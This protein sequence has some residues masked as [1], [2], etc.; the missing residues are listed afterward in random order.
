MVAADAVF[1]G[2]LVNKIS[3]IIVPGIFRYGPPMRT[4][5]RV[6]VENLSSR[7]S[8]QDLKDY[9]R[10]EADVTFADAHRHAR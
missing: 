2:K 4:P 3:I 5:Y 9:M 1:N 7:I 6:L 8:W 10:K